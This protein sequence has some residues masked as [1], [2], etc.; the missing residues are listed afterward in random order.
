MS[1]IDI[2]FGFVFT[3]LLIFF[4]D[5]LPENFSQALLDEELKE[6]P[7][8]EKSQIDK[9]AFIAEEPESF[10]Y[11]IKQVLSTNNLYIRPFSLSN[12]ILLHVNVI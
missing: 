2:I 9:S 6:R 1:S 11:E 5:Q 7:K 4:V 12:K 8:F 10:N 3:Y